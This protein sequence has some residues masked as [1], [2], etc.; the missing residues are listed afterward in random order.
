MRIDDL[1]E[2]GNEQRCD[3][4]ISDIRANVVPKHP[5][6][7]IWSNNLTADRTDPGLLCR[8]RGIVDGLKSSHAKSLT[9]I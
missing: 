5:N 7:K 8:L 1:I 6:L 3:A 2:N 4:F 9:D